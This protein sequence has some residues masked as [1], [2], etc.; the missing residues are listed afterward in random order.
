MKKKKLLKVRRVSCEVVKRDKK[1]VLLKSIVFNMG[2]KLSEKIYF[3]KKLTNLCK[4]YSL[5]KVR[6]ICVVSGRAKGITALGL[7][8][9][10]FREY[11]A[12]GVLPGYKKI[13]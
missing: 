7:S 9:M 5:S 2:I 4:R 8:R 3:Q 10:R 12:L 13:S 11:Q 6:S 1:V